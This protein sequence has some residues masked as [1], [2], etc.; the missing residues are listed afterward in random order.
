MEK[1]KKKSGVHERCNLDL[2]CI[3]ISFKFKGSKLYGISLSS[4]RYSVFLFITSLHVLGG[5]REHYDHPT[6]IKIHALQ[7]LILGATTFVSSLI[8]ITIN[9]H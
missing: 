5:T 4:S 3:Y 2:I 1:G 9:V 7:L 6:V 8:Y